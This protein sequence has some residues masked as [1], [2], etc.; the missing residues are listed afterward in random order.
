MAK[1]KNRKPK[2]VSVQLIPPDDKLGRPLYKLLDTIV[3]QHH[4]HLK[5][6]RIALAWKK[7]WKADKDGILNLAK[8][9]KATDLGREMAEWDFVIL[10]NQSAWNDL[11]DA[12][13][14]AL[15]DHQCC[16]CAAASGKDGRQQEDERGR[17]VW[18]TRKHDIEDFREVI[19]RHG[20]YT[21]DLEAF[22]KAANEA[23]ET[24][25]FPKIAAE[26]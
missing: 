16:H 6:C 18:R 4:D 20:L 26:A 11:N 24:P 2:K 17:L 14:L 9:Q 22:V 12:Q 19:A 10:L 21:K 23:R 7:S 5:K 15:L 13:R 25:L 1:T 3:K 8:C